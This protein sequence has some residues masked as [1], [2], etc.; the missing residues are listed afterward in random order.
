MCCPCSLQVM[1]Y[2]YEQTTQANPNDAVDYEALEIPSARPPLGPS[3]ADWL[4]GT[5]SGKVELIRWEAGEV[6]VNLPGVKRNG[7]GIAM[8][9][10]EYL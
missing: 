3:P 8:S 4:E 2:I 9:S 1:Y 10:L 7:L 5:W 6:P